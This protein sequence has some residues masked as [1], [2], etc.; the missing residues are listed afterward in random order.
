VSARVDR[1]ARG[2]TL[3]VSNITIEEDSWTGTGSSTSAAISATA[4][5]TWTL[6][7][8]DNNVAIYRPTGTASVVV[9]GCI[10]YNPSSGTIIPNS[11]VLFVN[12]NTNPPTYHGSAIT[13]WPTIATVTCPQPPPP[14][15]TLATAEEAK[16]LLESRLRVS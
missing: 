7:S 4:Q 5:V 6:E 15:S 14:F 12:Y 2:R 13:Q 8:T 11:G 1:G 10:T 3:V 16:E 9:H